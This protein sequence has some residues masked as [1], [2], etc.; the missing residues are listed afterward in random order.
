MVPSKFAHQADPPTMRSDI[1]MEQAVG[2]KPPQT[3]VGPC[4]KC[5][6]PGN[7]C[8]YARLPPVVAA[9]Q[10][11]SPCIFPGT[12]KDL[13]W[14]PPCRAGRG[15]RSS[16][17]W[18]VAAKAVAAAHPPQCRDAERPGRLRPGR[19][20]CAPNHHRPQVSSNC[21]I[22]FSVFMQQRVVKASVND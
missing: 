5:M 12:C 15:L 9:P 18:A 11:C 8:P 21:D 13:M 16:Q 3:Q 17:L 22:P 19:H 20:M 1:V 6:F 10:R 4:L 14:M 2:P 7:C